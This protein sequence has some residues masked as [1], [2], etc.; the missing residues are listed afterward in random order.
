MRVCVGLTHLDGAVGATQGGGQH[1]KV[2]DGRA[3]LAQTRQKVV[4]RQVLAWRK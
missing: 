1:E 4:Q 3:G 2:D